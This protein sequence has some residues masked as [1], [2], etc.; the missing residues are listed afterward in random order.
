MK[1]NN[2]EDLHNFR[3][4]PESPRPLMREI[5]PATPFPTDALGSILGDTTRAIQDM[6]Q[7]PIA[8]CALSTLAVAALATQGQCD[9]VMTT[10]EQKPTSNFLMSLGVSGE[11]KSA[12]DKLALRPVRE[13]ETTLRASHD[14]ELLSYMNTKDAW[15]G[16]R[17]K[18]KKESAKAN[19]DMKEGLD[20]IGQPPQ[21]P[22]TPM[23]T[24]SDPTYEGL[25]RL[26]KEGHP[27]VGI[28]TA[29]GGSFICG[30]GMSEENKLRTSTGLS[31]AWDG[32]PVRRARAGEGMMILPGRRVSMHL[33][34]QPDIAA[35]MLN[36]PLLS[37]Q[38]ILSRILLAAPDSTIGDRPWH[39]PDPKSDGYLKRYSAHILS[40]LEMEL[41]LAQDKKNELD[42]QRHLSL[43]SEARMMWISYYN[44]NE[45]KLKTGGTYDQIRG[46]GS[47]IPE[48]ATRLAGVL[49]FIKDPSAYQ[50]DVEHL[51][52]GIELAN[53]FAAEALRLFGS[54]KISNDIR[55]AQKLLYWLQNKWKE[56]RVSLPD[57]YQIGPNELRES[58]SA[59]K[60]V[61]ILEDHG[62]L[63]RLQGVHEVDGSRRKE[64]WRIVK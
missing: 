48:H 25:C 15:E 26:L 50:I 60:I 7:A 33:M 8:L 31:S 17:E 61:A 16:A 63:V 37:A 62:H 29:E 2:T 9:V 12:S 38:G 10:T 20:S 46:L 14:A 24:T 19:S 39:E 1:M 44:D 55:L 27:S 30:H 6:T 40:L 57:I 21:A 43:S 35:I 5:P 36:D 23:L 64:V 45:A 42:I 34:V 51:E 32:D 52:A 18:V 59:K 49:T 11:R 56:A 3:N 53:Y 58:A 28:F 13:Y 4:E 22:L 41:P 54:S 47:K